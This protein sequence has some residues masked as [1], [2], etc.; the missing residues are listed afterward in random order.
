[1]EAVLILAPSLISNSIADPTGTYIRPYLALQPRWYIFCTKTYSQEK[2]SLFCVQLVNQECLHQVGHM[3]TPRAALIDNHVSFQGRLPPKVYSDSLSYTCSRFIPPTTSNGSGG[4]HVFGSR[5]EQEA[6]EATNMNS[7]EQSTSA[8]FNG[9]LEDNPIGTGL[10]N[11]RI[12]R[13]L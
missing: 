9:I 10:P 3:V 5:A 11:V 7:S 6:F 1:M 4:G 8:A 13:C 2:L 12:T